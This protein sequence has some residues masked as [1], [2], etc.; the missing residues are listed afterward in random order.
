MEAKTIVRPDP[1]VV[2]RLVAQMRG[3][4]GERL[5]ADFGA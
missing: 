4:Y 3:D 5:P 1:D 2:A